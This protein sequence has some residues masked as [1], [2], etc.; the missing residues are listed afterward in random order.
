MISNKVKNDDEI[1]QE[2][3]RF[4]QS[5]KLNEALKGFQYL[6]RKYPNSPDLLN[7]LGTL[8]LQ[9]GKDINGCEY[10]E[11]SLKINSNQPIVSFNLGNSYMNQ[12][13]ISKAINF[14]EITIKK[15]P[16][17]LE[18]YKKKG[19]ILTNLNNHNEALDC[20][21]K[22]IKLAPEDKAILNAIGVN[23]LE[24]GDANNALKY[25]KKCI[26]IDKT[27]AIFYN[28]AGL[29]EYKINAFQESIDSFNSAIKLSPSIGYFFSN[30]GLSYQALNKIKFALNDFDK[31]ISIDPS[32]QDAYWNKSLINL[33]QGNYR[34]GW[35]LYEYRWQ[36]FA[37]KWAR[38][39][40]KKL[41]L[42]DESLKN[43]I[44]FI[45]PEQGHGDFIHCYRYISL[46]KKMQ[47][48]KIILEV[49][50]SFYRLVSSQD[51]E[52]NIIGPNNKIPKFDFYCPIMSLPHAFKTDILTIPNK[53]PYLFLN[54]I[55]TE[56]EKDNSKKNKLKIGVCWAGN[57]SHKNNH[58]RSM[59]IPD[60]SKLFS[61]PFEFHSLQKEVS[62]ESLSILKK[63]NII[64]HH[65]SL[66]DFSDT[67]KLI[68]KIDIIISV[69]TVIAHLAGALGKKTFL[70]LPDKSS[71]LWMDERE[72]SPWYPTIKI[73]RQK[74][75]GDWQS[76]IKKIIK[77]LK[78]C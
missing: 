9:L 71:F 26:S 18:A 28:N 63:F 59:S 45:Y 72:D 19:E 21:K 42:G 62:Q 51:R 44:I 49:T 37:K 2:S 53:C 64:D 16:N 73:F 54:E 65:N 34:E 52:I 11:K 69:D 47:P 12:K 32:Y 39:Y 41:W 29:A 77:E 3:I 38:T 33:F 23:L 43:K 40:S 24:L 35:R 78:S 55:K 17:Y 31:S 20:F 13:K 4:H 75:L 6:I 10:L 27:I 8:N 1:F 66:E 14:F 68:D 76:P 36:S 30:R 7:S 46:L 50:K 60:M 48:K 61:L 22:A 57:P 58:N 67:A 56:K 25:F 15:A 70:L 74:I 5:G